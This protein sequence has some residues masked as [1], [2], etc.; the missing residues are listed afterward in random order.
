MKKILAL[1][2]LA[3]TLSACSSTS[4]SSNNNTQPIP[5]ATNSITNPPAKTIPAVPTT[6]KMQGFQATN[7][8]VRSGSDS[9]NSITINGNP[10][11]IIPQSFSVGKDLSMIGANLNGITM[12]RQV[13]N[14]SAHKHSRYGF[15]SDNGGQGAFFAHG[16]LSKEVP[17]DGF[18]TY[19]GSAIY[20]AHGSKEFIKG[21]TELHAQFVTKTVGGIIDF[22]TKIPTIGVVA[23]INNSEF[24]QVGLKGGFYGADAQEIAGVFNDDKG[25]G[26][27]G[28]IRSE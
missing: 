3:L 22:D 11:Q 1:S 5:S 26:A 10:L 8:I 21:T 15:A 7:V 13:P 6:G 2:A 25:A 17:K 14:I 28:G 16:E 18:V 20:R 23:D 27:F 9:L 24:A 4:N 19:K 12:D